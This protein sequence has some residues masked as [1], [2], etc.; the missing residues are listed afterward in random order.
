MARDRI[1]R[2]CASDL[3]AVQDIP[4]VHCRISFQSGHL[5]GVDEEVRLRRE[6][7]SWWERLLLRAAIQALFLKDTTH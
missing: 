4:D 6:I 5:V 1:V 7:I 3:N 2:G